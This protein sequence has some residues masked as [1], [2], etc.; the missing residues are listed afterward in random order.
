MIKDIKELNFPAYATLETASVTIADMGD[1]T[2]NSQVKIDGDVVPD[3]SY[4]WEIEFKGERYIHPVRTPQGTKDNSSLRAKIDLVFQHWAIYEM[5]HQYFVEM[6][7]TTAGIAIADK[8][9]ASLGLNLGDFVTAFNLVL[10]HY[11]DGRIVIRLNPEWQY[12]TEAKFVSISYSYIWDVLQQMHEIYGVRWALK[13]NADGVCEILMG[14]SAEE[15]SHIFEYGFEGGLLSVQRQVQSTDIR[16]RLL[17]RGGEKNLPL[18]YFKDKD[19]NNPLFEADPDWI[20]ELANIAFTELRGKTFRDYV[21]GWKAKHY[22]GVSMDEPTE[23]YLA[24][25]NAEKFD[26]IEYVDDK[27][28]IKKYGVLVGALDNNDNIY[29]SIQGAPGNV[30]MIVDAEQVTDDDVDAS[31]E[32]D[33]VE[34]NIQGMYYTKVNVHPDSEVSIDLSSKNAKVYF[35]VPEGTKGTILTPSFSATGAVYS[36]RKYKSVDAALITVYSDKCSFSIHNK[37]TDEEVSHLNIPP[38]EYYYKAIVVASHI[39]EHDINITG[40][41]SAIKL[42]TS[43]DTESGWHQTFDIWVRN[44]WNSDRNSGET[45]EEYADRV[46]LPIL[47]DRMGNEARVVFASGWLSFSSDWE[48]PIVDYAFDDSKDGSEWRLTLAKSEAELEASGKYIP[49]EGYNASSGD[50]FF[51][52]GIDMPH[53][54]VVW[55][56]QRVDDY[57]RDSLLQTAEIKPTWVIKTDKVRLNQNREGARLIDSLSAGSQIRLI[58]KQFISGAYESLYVQSITYNWTA[59]TILYPDV[60]LVVS[61]KVATVKNPVAQMQGSIETLQRQVGSLSNIQQIIRQVCDQLYLRKDGVEDLSKSPTRFLGKVT[62]ENFRQGQIGGRDWGIYRDESGNAILEADKFV[63]RQG[64]LVSNLVVNEAT[65]VGGLQINSAAAMRVSA[66]ENTDAGYVCYFDQQQGSVTNKFK[67]DDIAFC[68]KFDSENNEVKFYK[69]RIIAI[70]ETSVTL[71]K[72]EVNG[73]GIPTVDD[74]IIHYGNYTD[75]T[76]QFVIIR[77]VIGGG[78]ERMLMALDSVTSDGV[79]YYFAG[80]DAGSNARWFV[81]DAEHYAK[82]ENGIFSISGRLDVGTTGLDNVKEW[83]DNFTSIV[84]GLIQSGKLSLGYLDAEGQFHVMSGSNGEYDPSLPGGG[85]ASW[86]GGEMDGNSAKALIRFDGSG[87]LAN[88]NITWDNE[89]YGS[90]G[91]GL[92]TWG[93]DAN[94]KKYIQIS[95]EVTLGGD[96]DDSIETILAFIAK[97]NSWFEEDAN[98]NIMVK[99]R[100]LYSPKFISSRGADPNQGGGTGGGGSSYLNELL[101]VNANPIDLKTGDMLV[102]DKTSQKYVVINKSVFA[103]ASSLNEYQT[104]VSSSNKIPYAYISGVPTALKNPYAL[105]IAGKAYDGS[106]EVTI[107]AED[108]GAIT[109]LSNYYTKGEVDALIPSLA[110]YATETF[111]NT[112]IANLINGAPTTLDTLKEIADALADNADVVE[113][114]ESAIG[115]KADKTTVEALDARLDTAETNITNLTNNKLNKSVWEKFFEEDANG[116]LK[117]KVGLY[118]T[119]FISARGADANAG[120]GGGGAFSLYTWS[121]IK[122]ISAEVSGAAPT[123]FALKQAYDELNT[124]LGARIDT[125]AN[126]ATKVSVSQTLTTGTEIG[127]IT[128]DGVS[129]ALYAPSSIAWGSVTEKP[130]FATVATS[131]KYSDLSGLPTIPSIAGL[132]SESWVSNNYLAKSGGTIDGNII[133]NGNITITRESG[134]LYL[135]TTSTTIPTAINFFKNLVNYGGLGMSEKNIPC[136]LDVNNTAYT[137]IHSGNYS[138]YALPLSGGTITGSITLSGGFLQLVADGK[139]YGY[140]TNVS[141][142]EPIYLKD[143][144]WF[145]LIHSGNIGSH[146]AGGITNGTTTIALT[147]NGRL[148]VGTSPLQWTIGD[149][150]QF[151]IPNNDY[152]KLTY[153]NGSAW[154]QIAFTDSN[155]ASAT[156]LATPRTIWG[157]SFDGS[158][159]VSGALSGVTNIN[160]AITINSSG[161]VTI[162]SSDYAGTTSKLY[163]DGDIATSSNLLFNNSQGIGFKTTSGQNIS[164]YVDG[165]NNLHLGYQNLKNVRIDTGKVLIGTTTDDGVSKL[166]VAGNFAQS[167]DKYGSAHSIFHKIHGGRAARYVA[168]K[169][170]FNEYAHFSS[171]DIEYEE[172]NL[173]S[174]LRSGNVGIGTTDPKYKLDVAGTANFTGAVSMSSTL[175]TTGTIYSA[176]GV[177]SSGYVSARGADSSSDCRLKDNIA[178]LRN[179]LNYVLGTNYVSFVWKDTREKSIGI[180]AQEEMGRE[181]GCLVQKHS[182]TYSY[183]YGQHTALLGA[184]LQEEDKKVEELKAEIARLNAKVNELETRLNS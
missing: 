38:G 160:S 182:E 138:D 56:E 25:Y 159:D 31:V 94:G 151:L 89:G 133:L 23:A 123:A 51:F 27:E 66:V 60:E 65:Y 101:D 122:D 153:Y 143:N 2:I 176:T 152:T 59:D 14:Y 139:T 82:Y 17:G 92:F 144:S 32:N 132:A 13:T 61:D 43:T 126:K 74:E 5:K 18:R 171:L 46:W 156:K 157:Q 86:W 72:T 124:S 71:S 41:V 57:K 128:I 95:N 45:D 30:D 20:P 80:K 108:L 83:S 131:G 127:K 145:Q 105:T 181:W 33:S 137:L 120:G 88:K 169:S 62:G 24:G 165:Y 67:V 162:G 118:S 184:A 79:E 115:T 158:G 81:G 130:T 175:T 85:I 109:D 21:K 155:V 168:I 129:K 103:L 178:P 84:G 119:S 19:P 97:V 113:A 28:S 77:D 112:A 47:G 174:I 106:G 4:D 116:N 179:A 22:G 161:N 76:R 142:G 8:Y 75:K 90:I 107:T 173:V 180:I 148:N 117:V 140:N 154:K 52:I 42:I 91:G 69:R 73:D 121:Q 104:K 125:L 141:N 26:P 150:T 11:F 98:G 49:Y 1:R 167:V 70:S 35:T 9:I 102:W 15:V 147:S 12:D 149:G 87:F 183:L 10:N 68:Q 111:V 114:L 163:V 146:N 16:N 177:Y 93:Q 40:S 135:N 37:D 7:S 29:P 58:N 110:G 44:I 78:Y 136:F 100:G 99:N 36:D 63:A 3:F 6:A 134:A 54:Y 50:R 64:I 164:I 55:A 53:Q 39:V 96:G 34:S 172:G 170:N 48:F 166:Q